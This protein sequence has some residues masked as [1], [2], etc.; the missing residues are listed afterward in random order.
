M[1]RGGNYALSEYGKRLSEAIE[2]EIPVADVVQCLRDNL[3]AYR[4]VRVGKDHEGIDEPDFSTR[5][6]AAELIL[7]LHVPQRKAIDVPAK[8]PE[9]ESSEPIHGKL[10]AKGE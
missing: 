3:K 7:N 5:Q 1:T 10:K 4:R 6:K 2:Q 8:P 9:E